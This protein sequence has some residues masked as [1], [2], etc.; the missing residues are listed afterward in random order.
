[1]AP[2]VEDGIGDLDIRPPF[3]KRH[4]NKIMGGGLI[5]VCFLAFKLWKYALRMMQ[6]TVSGLTA[7][8]GCF[9]LGLVL[10]SV[11]LFCGWKLLVKLASKLVLLVEWLCP[12]REYR[13]VNGA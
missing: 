7:M 12:G 10:I 2:R 9:V 11:I 3:A 5:L 8:L 6:K 4:E 1:M 13:A